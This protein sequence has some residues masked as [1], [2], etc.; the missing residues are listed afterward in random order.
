MKNL[1]F[2][3]L[4]LLTL[5]LCVSLNAQDYST[6]MSSG[7]LVINEVLNVRI[8]GTN[9][10]QVLI[11]TQE[12]DDEVDERAE[13][14]VEINALGLTD[15]TGI[16]L[17]AE[18]SS[19]ELVIHPISR[20]SSREY[21]FQVPQGV[22]IHYECFS[23]GAE[24]VHISDVS[25]E[26]EVSTNHNSIVLENTS[27]P[28]AANSVHGDIDAIFD[29]VS[30]QNEITLNSTHGYVDVSIPSDMGATFDLSTDHGKIFTDLELKIEGD[31]EDM[32]NLSNRD[33][34]GT[35]NNGGVH[36]YLKSSHGKIYLRKK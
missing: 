18:K 35:F 1:K 36:F 8:E 30:A 28:I 10:S 22:S 16:G 17:A 3:S 25:S 32:R 27:G 9:G 6:G 29:N 2:L 12:K 4:S 5:G 34:S 31:E 13:G 26:I 24:T 19:G 33:I 11:S 15:N 21:I 20:S 7:K 14:L 23:V